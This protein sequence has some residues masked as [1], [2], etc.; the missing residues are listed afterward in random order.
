[1]NKF[2]LFQE[3]KGSSTVEKIYKCNLPHQQI[4]ASDIQLPSVTINY[5]CEKY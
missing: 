2:I 4:R 1:M 3:Y 5:S